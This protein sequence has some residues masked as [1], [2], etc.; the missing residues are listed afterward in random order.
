MTYKICLL[1]ALLPLILFSCSDGDEANIDASALSGGGSL[2]SASTQGY[3]IMTG[4][5][6]F[7]TGQTYT[8]YSGSTAYLR[9]TTPL[10]VSSALTIL[11]APGMTPGASYSLQ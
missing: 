10:S 6:S 11:S 5:Q 7:V 8:L 4:Q 9:F 1:T 2:S 3:Y